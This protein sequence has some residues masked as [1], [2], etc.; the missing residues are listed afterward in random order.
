MC[1]TVA[2][3]AAPF[4]KQLQ[5]DS[6]SQEQL[7][8]FDSVHDKTT[9]RCG[10]FYELIV[11]FGRSCSLTS[12]N[13]DSSLRY[14]L[15]GN[16]HADSIKTGLAETAMKHGHALRIWKDNFP[17]GMAKTTPG[18][19]SNE[20]MKYDIDVVIIHNSP[21]YF[22]LADTQKLVA[23]AEQNNFSVVLIDPVP[24]WSRNVPL[25]VWNER[26]GNDTLE[27]QN[28]D[29]HYNKVSKDL[30]AIASISSDA[31]TRFEVADYFCKPL[32]QKTDQFGV[33]IYY[34][35]HHLNLRGARILTPTFEKIFRM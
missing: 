17:L 1:I 30:V 16:S 33:P 23:L 3:A 34:D 19:V 13:Y 35:R 22:N 29:I 6:Y 24:T 15:I 5:R 20:A 8:I 14:L 12:G 11:P 28:I 25:L 7:P 32:C 9:F 21:G 18:N 4:L 27:Q 26:I 10:A 2:V 31:F